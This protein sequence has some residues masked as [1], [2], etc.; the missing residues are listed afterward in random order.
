MKRKHKKTANTDTWTFVRQDGKL[1]RIVKNC[2]EVK[3]GDDWSIVVDCCTGD[4]FQIQCPVEVCD[5]CGQYEGVRLYY[6]EHEHFGEQG[7]WVG[8]CEKCLASP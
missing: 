7:G 2:K 4:T 5:C 1:C 3:H 8:I 6:T